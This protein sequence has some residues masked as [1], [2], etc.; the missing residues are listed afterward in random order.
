MNRRKI[1][2]WLLAGVAAVDPENLVAQ[3]LPDDLGPQT[4]IAMGKA[5]SAMTQGVAVKTS[6][7]G[8]CVTT[9][10]GLVPPDVELMF[11]D[12]PIPGAASLQAG[13]RLLEVKDRTTLALV[14]GGG[15][16]LCE[17]PIP[18]LDIEFLAEVTTALLTSGLPIETMN[19]VRSHLSMI[20]CGGL[21]KLKTLVL[22][23]VGGQTP[24]VVSS[25]PTAYTERDPTAAIEVLRQ[26]DIPVT[27]DEE[28]AINNWP[29]CEPFE[30][31]LIV[32]GDGLTAAEGV[33]SAATSEGAPVTINQDWISSSSVE[34]LERF[35]SKAPE[36]LSIRAGEPTLEVGGTGTGGR[37]THVALEAATRIQNSQMIFAALATDGTDGRSEA[38]GAIVN[39]TT[40]VR[41]G[42]PTRAL[43]NFDSAHYLKATGDIVDIGE[44]GT[45]VADLWVLWR[46]TPNQNLY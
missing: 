30:S 25:G 18:G 21:G 19:L 7:S 45:N 36:G 13:E 42:D 27:D 39:G 46:P 33:A 41:G 17:V 31:Q 20:K 44:T 26:L 38:S 14:S 22:S 4:V 34:E 5:A 37:N 1:L 16:S 28:H 8:V 32:V 3:A 24:E 43:I 23:D 2:D 9:S 10:P 15:S 40:I 29:G 35:L 11:G 12:H 6:V